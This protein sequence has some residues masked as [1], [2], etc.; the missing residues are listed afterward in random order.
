MKSFQLSLLA[1]TCL[2]LS[3][4]PVAAQDWVQ[5][6]GNNRDGVAGNFAAP[7]EWP[8]ELVKKWSVIVGNGVSSPSLMGGKIY[9]MALQGSNEVMRCLDAESG[10]E[11]WTDQYPAQP[12]SGPASGFPGTRSSPAIADG[13]VV[14]LGVDGTVSSWNAESGELNWRNNDNQ[15]N[16]PRFSTSGSPLIADGMCVIQF[17]SDDSGG[18]VAYDLKTGTEKWKWNQDGAAYGS[19]VLMTV[20]DKKVVLCPTKSQLVAVS[21]ADGTGVWSMEYPGRY[22]ASTPVVDG[23]TAYIADAN[24]GFMALEFSADGDKIASKEI[25]RNEDTETTVMYNSPVLVDGMMF[26]LSNSNLLFCVSTDRGKMNW[27]RTISSGEQAAPQP[28]PARTEQG[29]GDAAGGA[30]NQQQGA[31]GRQRGAG[32][33]GGGGRGG[34][35]GGGGRGGYGSVV[36]AGSVLLG[37][38]PS[39]E[40]VVYQPNGDEFRELARYKVSETPTYAYPI[41][42]G[43]RIYVKDQ[44]SVTMWSLK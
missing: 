20:G 38:S 1:T 10:K 3:A 44:D 9:V 12:A 19:P 33:G 11:L 37:L 35:G 7:A 29:G 26:G 15:G 8:R 41:P 36:S 31:G 14:T 21:M 34:R 2:L 24:R 39:S 32:G 4:G 28:P 23:Q 16:V 22:N 18:I 43:D 6:R 42:V 27:N 17:G 30:G 13:C 40:L 5:W 25:W